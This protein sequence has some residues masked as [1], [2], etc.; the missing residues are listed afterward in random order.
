MNNEELLG[1]APAALYAF[2]FFLGLAGFLT[3][4]HGGYLITNITF[5]I[6][7]II[8]AISSVRA[9]YLFFVLYLH[10]HHTRI[11]WQYVLGLVSGLLVPLPLSFFYI[12]LRYVPGL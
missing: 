11:T 4:E 7:G 10:N 1:A 6:L 9:F 12:S 8:F 3:L 2:L 5:L